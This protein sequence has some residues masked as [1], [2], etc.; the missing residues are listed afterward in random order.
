MVLNKWQCWIAMTSW[1]EHALTT[2][3]NNNVKLTHQQEMSEYFSQGPWHLRLNAGVALPN[4]KELSAW[5]RF[6]PIIFRPLTTVTS[7]M[8]L[9]ALGRFKKGG[10]GNINQAIFFIFK[11][12]RFLFCWKVDSPQWLNRNL[13]HIRHS[14]YWEL[15][16]QTINQIPPFN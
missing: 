11:R 7:N 9:G 14:N 6:K 15:Y 12:K 4:C 13:S 1:K 8:C 16:N 5:H 10:V 3:E 2:F